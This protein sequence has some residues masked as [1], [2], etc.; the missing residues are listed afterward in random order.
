MAL[1]KQVAVEKCCDFCESD[2]N[3]KWFC[4]DC[5]NNLCDQCRRTHTRI[6]LCKTH[7]ILP[8]S[9]TQA[10]TLRRTTVLFDCPEHAQSC[11]FQC[12]T[13]NKQIC[14]LC[15]TS[16]HNKHDFLALDQYAKSIRENL[17]LTLNSKSNEVHTITE[18]LQTL[19]THKQ[20]YDDWMNKKLSEVDQ[21]FEHL[22]DELQRLRTEIHDK[23]DQRK[24]HDII[25][26]DL[27]HKRAY[28]F[29]ERLQ[30]QVKVLSSELDH[31][32]DHDLAN[33]KLKIETECN[34]L[35][36]NLTLDLPKFPCLRLIRKEE[37]HKDILIKVLTKIMKTDLFSL[38]TTTSF[39]VDN[40]T[41]VF[42]EDLHLDLTIK[43]PGCK[44]IWA[45]AGCDD[46]KMWVG[47]EDK[48]LRL[49][50]N[51][52]NVVK[53]LQ[54]T[55]SAAHLAVLTS[56]EVLC[57]NGYGIDRTSTIQKVSLNFDV[58]TFTR[59]SQAVEVGPLASTKHG[60]VLVGIRN[61]IGRGEVLFLSHSGKTIN[62]VAQVTKEVEKVAIN[63]EDQVFVKDSSCIWIM[64][65]KGEFINQ[66]ELKNEL[67]GVRGFVCDRFSN[68]VCFRSGDVSSIRVYSSHSALLKHFRLHLKSGND[69]VIDIGAI[70]AN[71]FIW[72]KEDETIHVLKYLV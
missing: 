27:Q 21:V 12:R 9:E 38:K 58:T 30:Y 33:L 60:N 8:I 69:R 64:S 51:F 23:I 56:G 44:Y 52:G 50:D 13:C 7:V 37:E 57:S 55:Q 61:S 6:P 2:V 4:R 49:V 34:K 20:T 32:N 35:R 46:G 3:V 16:S 25:T 72:L 65:L 1:S 66:I 36:E 15:L 26:M 54:M 67:K 29:R 71:D 43:L 45:M 28:E 62:K 14:V 41:P 18:T 31:C 47:T 22:A 19:S 24:N 68:L 48:K 59:L 42:M 53:C 39:D 17:Y 10:A 63:E 11:Q 5:I 40:E 70:D